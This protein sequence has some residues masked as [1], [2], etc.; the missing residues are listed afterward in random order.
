MDFTFNA[1]VYAALIA[2]VVG[3]V[4]CTVIIPYLKKFKVGQQVRDD[5]PKTHLIKSGTPTMGGVMIVLSL[6]AAAVFFLPGN[7]EGIALIA[8]T[9]AF[10]L[11][12]S[13]DDVRKLTKKRSLG[14]RAYQKML[15]QLAVSVAFVAYWHTLDGFSSAILVPFVGVYFDLGIFY[16]P[17]I[18]FIILG[19]VNGANLTDGL[20]GLAAGVTILIVAFFLFV[21]LDRNSGLLPLM[22][23]AAGSLLAFLWFNA[24]PAK[25]FMGDTGSLALGGFV[26]GTAVFLGMPLFLGIV[27]LVYVVQALSCIIQV[28]YFKISKGKRVFKMAP[29]HHHFELSGWPETKIVALAYIV[30]AVLCLVGYLA[31]M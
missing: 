6:L 31:Y 17:I 1:A 4:L 16:A 29:I 23:A 5:G 19:S 12:G 30:T 18:I 2:F 7:R 15:L 28:G 20:D 13:L 21:S 14:L 8:M 9:V 11:I 3:I 24:H 25:V 10:A 22:G 27:A 26:A